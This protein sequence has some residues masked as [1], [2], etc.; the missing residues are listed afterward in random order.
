MSKCEYFCPIKCEGAP[1]HNE[2]YDKNKWN[3]GTPNECCDCW[4]NT[5]KCEDCI[6]EKSSECPLT[7]ADSRDIIEPSI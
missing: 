1:C 4:F 2:L 7:N 6:F 5:G 3:G